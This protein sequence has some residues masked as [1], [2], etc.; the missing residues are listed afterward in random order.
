VD[1]TVTGT[2]RTAHLQRLQADD[3]VGAGLDQISDPTQDGTAKRR[4][5]PRPRPVVERR[6]G[7]GHRPIGVGGVALGHLHRR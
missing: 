7:G 3:L 6:L 1:P 4:L 5:G 2:D